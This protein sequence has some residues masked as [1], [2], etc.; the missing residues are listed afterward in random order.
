VTGSTVGGVVQNT[1]SIVDLT[2]PSGATGIVVIQST[3]GS[4]IN[5]GQIQ[6]TG[7]VGIGA[8][9]STI[10]GDVVNNGTIALSN[11]KPHLTYSTIILSG[12]NSLPT[13]LVA[14]GGATGAVINTG[15]INAPHY[16][17]LLGDGS[18]NNG[19]VIIP[20]GIINTGTINGG[21]AAI[22][23]TAAGTRPAITVN[24]N[25]GAING[26]VN[27]SQTIADVFNINAGAVTGNV[28][29]GAASRLNVTGGTL[30]GNVTG[31]GLFNVNRPD[32]FTFGGVF[33]GSGAFQ[34]DGAG[35]TIFTGA[36]TYT[37][38]TTINAGTLQLG[39]G[40]TTGSIVGNVLD[41][42]TLAFNRSD[43]STFGGVISG[44]GAVQQSGT[45]TTVFNTIHTYTGAT[46]V[47]AGTLIVNGSIVSSSGVTVNPG[48]TIGG[49]GTLPKT[50]INGGAL[51]PG[52]SIGTITVT[53]SLSFVG[54]GNY[55]VEVSPSAADKT[56]VTGAPGTA[57]LAGTL[58]AIGTG[59]MYTVGTKYTVLNATGGVSGTFSNLAISGSFGATKP[60]IEYDAN[61]VYLV[62]DPNAISPFLVGGSR[63]QR[64][65]AGAIDTAIASG[66]QNAP[67]IALFNLAGPQLNAALDQLSGEV[68]ASTAGVLVDESLYARSAVL[69]R[70]RQASYG[71]DSSM[72]SLSAGGPQAFQNGEE[73]SPLAYGKS[74]I[75]T[76]APPLTAHSSYDVVFWA[77]GFGA[78]GSFNGDGNAASV[79]RD[80]AGFFSGVDTRVGTN[81]R[82]G[83]AAG[84][85][86]SRNNLDGRGSSSVET[87]HLA[88][89]G[90]WSFGSFNLRAGG[91]Y[92]WHSIDTSRAIVFPG[93]F[94]NATAH[95]DGRTGQIFGEAGYGF[96]FG[97]V[98]VE[99][100]AGAA[101]VHLKTD[102][103]IERGGAAAL[104]VAA[105]SFDVG[106]STLGVRAAN[107]IPVGHDM[108]L[109]PRG[110]LAWQH[111][112]NDVTPEARL[113]FIAAPVPFVIA[114]VPIARDSV[115]GEVGLDLAIGRNATVGI[116]YVG[117]L[118]RNVQDHAAKGKFSWKF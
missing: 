62:L 54:P 11:I 81:G 96:A 103:A 68:H 43:T 51:S 108:V 71:G 73:L 41:N 98:A 94:D 14:G 95:Y 25:G 97:K 86:G 47:N 70:L 22:D 79:K 18:G 32:N 66:S 114:G 88:G 40:G 91:A 53:G 12:T 78:R 75:V 64:A 26:A 63:N 111:A 89:Y 48:G 102:A 118:A 87:G 110:S 10:N 107:L 56:N 92:A 27:L 117:Q 38:G 16:G 3:T 93:F 115:L 15:T 46:T 109:V 77:Q 83:I 39:N 20:G 23:L 13:T 50:A 24:Q 65:V 100:F 72:A 5:D 106:Y 36:N 37:G 85:T 60:H 1:G 58:S 33:S 116:S 44:T 29:G 113:A 76:K 112:F 9:S 34:K 90:G 80:L 105:N 55:I 30:S 59:G 8:S 101:W 52:N 19:T 2:F 74:P 84:Y 104:N 42:G 45:G 35:T 99:P 49:T 31:V 82:L 67:F 21:F 57:A 69:G 7:L 61:N 4:L 17:I 28:T 6:T